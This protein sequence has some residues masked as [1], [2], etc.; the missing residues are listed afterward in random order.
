MS[1]ILCMLELSVQLLANIRHEHRTDSRHNPF[2]CFSQQPPSLLEANLN[3][4]SDSAA[5]RQGEYLQHD[6]DDTEESQTDRWLIISRGSDSYCI[7]GDRQAN[8]VVA[9]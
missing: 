7:T 9:R 6:D 8:L 3:A 5:D 4:P 2:D 1:G